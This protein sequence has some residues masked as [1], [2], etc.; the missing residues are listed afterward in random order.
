MLHMKKWYFLL[1]MLSVVC[2]C[3]SQVSGVSSAVDV[4]TAT[5]SRFK[6]I[7]AANAFLKKYQCSVSLVQQDA[8]AGNP[9]AQYAL[10]YLYYYGL[11]LSKD[12]VKAHEWIQKAAS[13]GQK[14]AMT[15]QRIMVSDD[16]GQN[17][18][19]AQPGSGD[20]SS[21][22]KFVPGGLSR[23]IE[24]QPSK[25]PGEKANDSEGATRK[26]VSASSSLPNK[27]PNQLGYSIQLMSSKNLTSLEAYMRRVKLPAGAEIY[28]RV[29]SGTE[30]S[31]VLV[32]G[33]YRTLDEARAAI[34]QLP[35][36]AVSQ[37]P[38]ARSL[39]GLSIVSKT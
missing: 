38:W 30:S 29:N 21:S 1:M 36:N 20:L 33:K 13:Q 35:Q 16:G 34:R 9:D 12:S 22:A 24:A 8:N 4:T 3:S 27:T 31:Y 17:S 6:S 7:C 39:L 32:T 28:S 5:T 2:G 37:K 11:G 14:L 26:F 18:I 15:A 23:V 10:G 25:A 19:K